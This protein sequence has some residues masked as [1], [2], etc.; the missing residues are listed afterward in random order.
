MTFDH[1]LQHCKDIKGEVRYVQ[2]ITLSINS[3]KA[4][5]LAT[6]KI[7]IHSN[8]NNNNNTKL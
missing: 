2:L 5:V 8:N 3:L 6:V 4:A 7:K 1:L